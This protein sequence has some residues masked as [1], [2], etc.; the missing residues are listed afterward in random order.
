[1]KDLETSAVIDILKNAIV[2]TYKSI[3]HTSEGALDC[4]QHIMQSYLEGK[5]DR[6]PIN[7]AVI[8]YLRKRNEKISKVDINQAMDI[9]F[10]DPRKRINDLFEIG[11][12][13]D[14]IDNKIDRSFFILYHKWGLTLGEIGECFDCHESFVSKRLKFI[15]NK[16]AKKFKL[17]GLYE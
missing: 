13:I 3:C 6:Q 10:E 12:V 17:M 8:D 9:V 7:F 14:L 2:K 16:I 1:M 15:R 4:V 5:S 11:N